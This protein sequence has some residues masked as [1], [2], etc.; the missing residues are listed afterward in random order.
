MGD[1]TL[2][3]VRARAGKVRLEA[4]ALA[5]VARAGMLQP[6]A[7]WK[8]A[9][10]SRALRHFGPVGGGVTAAAMQHGD[11]PG[12]I[13]EQG[14]LT[15]AEMEARSNALAA[16]LADRGVAPGAG[17]GILCRNHRGMLD[18]LFACAKGGYRALLLNTDFAAPQARDVCAREGV[19]VLIPAEEFTAV[20]A[21]VPVPS[22]RFVAWTDDASA[23][24]AGDTLESLIGGVSP[25]RRPAPPRPGAL[26][27]LTSGTTGTP[28]GASRPQPKSLVLPA[29]FLSKIPYRSGDTVYVAPPIFHAWG[30]SNSLLAVGLGATV[31]TSRR[32]DAASV[33]DTLEQRRC[34]GLVVVPV[35]L[36]RLMAIGEEA[37]AARDLSALRII[38]VSGSQLEAALATRTMDALGDV[39]YNLYGSTEVAYATIATPED[40]RTAPG[41]A[42]RPPMGT[43]VRLYDEQGRPAPDGAT[44]RIFVANGQGFDGYTGGGTKEVIDGL[45]STGDVGHFDAGGR[46][47]VDGRDDEMVVS[48][49]ENVFPREVEELLAAHEAVAEAAVIG[50]PDEDWGHR[51]VAFVALRPSQSVTE[52]EVKGHV[53]ENL[54]RYKVP[55]QV[56][57]LDELPRNPA[58]K[59]LKRQLIEDAIP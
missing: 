16:A 52:D 40:L 34:D 35:L 26:V 51:L 17:V 10:M 42:G 33:L 31:V 2:N 3:G 1:G 30:L 13:D 6:A 43:T 58:G 15:F 23:S 54:A 11:R 25:E 38:A 5:T 47:F 20:L 24:G 55:R 49:G 8:L 19:D 7:P 48:G 4:R 28:K 36:A 57:F 14:T 18:T 45:M 50:V 44:G 32:F 9:K 39:V 37:I 59:I 53:R 12:L 27:L 46:L 56:T 29:A 22:G 41:C 21:D